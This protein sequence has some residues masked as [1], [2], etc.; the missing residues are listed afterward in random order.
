MTAT[1]ERRSPAIVEAARRTLERPLASYQLVLG[2]TALLLGLG[3]IMVL[4]ASSVYALRNYGN[5]FAI[6]ERQLIFAVLGV[7]GAVIAARVPLT[8]P[9]QADPAVPAESRSP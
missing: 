9:A 3:L 5:S 2:S 8:L 6:V 7:I 4:S 1:A